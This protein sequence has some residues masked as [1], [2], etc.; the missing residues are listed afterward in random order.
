[1]TNELF[2]KARILDSEIKELRKTICLL[3]NIP[4]KDFNIR[5]STIG[6]GVDHSCQFILDGD[7][8]IEFLKG[9]LKKKE[10]KFAKL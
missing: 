7:L 2:N 5:A 3:K 9:E 10:Q 1:M 6:G 4:T 8:L